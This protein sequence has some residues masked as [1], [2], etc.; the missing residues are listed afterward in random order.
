M[1]NT[2]QSVE[3]EDGS[4]DKKYFTII[5]N[6]ILNHSTPY[7]RDVYIQMKRIAGEHGT[8]WTSQKTLAK[9]CGVSINRLKKSLSYLLDNKWIKYMGTKKVGTKGGGQE[10]NEYKIVD[11]WKMNGEFYEIKGVSPDDIPAKQGV[12]LIEPRECHKKIRGVS[13]DDNKEEP[14]NN[15]PIKEEAGD[16]ENLIKEVVEK[17]NSYAKPLEGYRNKT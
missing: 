14:I 16:K 6:Y 4:N 9:Q 17:W 2:N 3:I 7:D 5:P 15:K 1:T 10:V 12:S 8:C 13:L 11:L